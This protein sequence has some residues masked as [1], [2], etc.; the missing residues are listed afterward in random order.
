M[1][2]E[3]TGFWGKLERHDGEVTWHPLVDHCADVAA[4]FEA[5]LNQPV[6]RKR[7]AGLGGLDD[8]SK[9]QR[10]RLCYLAALHDLGKY[11]IGFQNKAYLKKTPTAGHVGEPSALF[12]SGDKIA[13]RLADA[14][15]FSELCSWCTEAETFGELLVAALA[16]HGKPV[17]LG[18]P[19]RSD[20]WQTMGELQPFEG[21]A[22]LACQ[23]RCWFPD[24]FGG[25]LDPLPAD[26]AFQHA[27]NGFL[28]LADWLGSDTKIFPFSE[29]ADHDRFAWSQERA[30]L[31]LSR[32]GLDA[33]GARAS[34]GS[35]RPGFATISGF[36]PRD[37]QRCIANLDID[38]EG[39][40][41]ILE[42]ETG[43]GKTEAALARFITLF[44]AGVVDGLYFALPTRTAATQIFE[45]VYKAVVRAFPDEQIRPPVIRAVPGYIA[46]D[47]KRA[48]RLPHFEVLWND[49]EDERYRY[50]GWAAE[51]PKRYLAGAVVVGTVD[52]I[53]LS[54]LAVSHAHLRASS[55]LR[56]LLVVDEVH[57]SDA[58]MTRILEA[59][60]QHHL[61][62]GGHALLMSATLGAVARLRLSGEAAYELPSLATASSTLYP[63]VTHRPLSES[64][65]QIPIQDSGTP[66]TIRV[67]TSPI[68]SSP[69]SVAEMALDAARQGARVIV[70]RNTVRDCIATQ[71]AIEAIGLGSD[72]QLL[73]R[74]GKISAPHHARFARKD[75]IAL[76]KALN[77]QFQPKALDK[78]CVVIATQTVQQSLDIDS[79]YMITD[80]CPID[81]WL[82][83]LGR[84]HRHSERQ[85]TQG[86]QTA[87]VT[88]LVPKERDLTPLIKQHGSA[89]GPHG[90]GTV[91]DDLRVLEASW[92]ILEYSQEVELPTMNRQLVE[93]ATHPEALATIVAELGDEWH[94]HYQHRSGVTHA[95]QGLA[96]LNLVNREV[97]FT[98][99][100][101]LFPSGDLSRAI[102][103]RLG[104]DDRLVRFSH[105]L[106][107]PFGNGIRELS[108]P[109]HMVYQAEPNEEPRKIESEYNEIMFTFGRV[110]YRYD[111]LGL[112]K[113]DKHRS[114]EERADD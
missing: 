26:S 16:H 36:D 29:E 9:G 85:C 88:V 17:A 100:D 30:C 61:A 8:L 12:G 109:G 84:L 37:A 102:K 11:N 22:D 64:I 60:L 47:D 5:L 1:E 80:L 28:T 58:Y 25:S 18:S 13:S 87:A 20:I 110:R 107:G 78:P 45:R 71:K 52:Q 50:R 39:S 44:H 113:L 34:L 103:T 108:L 104:V 82:Q 70:I 63:L 4:C 2:G 90:L 86:F 48:E 73:F 105:E 32:I 56:Q 94:K 99:K 51:A 27:F 81:V 19:V 98:H 49:D 24:A 6:I 59:V 46:A 57:A 33:T 10:A 14:I 40:L 31:A 72:S 38:K 68:M 83:R 91:Y 42:A 3:P 106:P 75:R 53:L 92:R 7:L 23:A 76:D 15:Q 65:R 21:I 114:T 97:P 111:H 96:R 43:S 79:D 66:K 89:S 112:R 95:E 93:Q 35:D 41:T 62:A 77:E 67:E 54:S 69:R 101:C 55:L 74:C